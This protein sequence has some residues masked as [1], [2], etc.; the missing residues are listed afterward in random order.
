MQKTS[1]GTELLKTYMS[2]FWSSV[3]Q[4]KGLKQSRAD[5][6]VTKCSFPCHVPS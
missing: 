1:L 5:A 4:L 2:V 3:Q 6:P